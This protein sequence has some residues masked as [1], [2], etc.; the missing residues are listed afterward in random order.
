MISFFQLSVNDYQ[1]ST[2]QASAND[3]QE[4]CEL[5]RRVETL[6]ILS[7]T[8]HPPD[9]LPEV[10]T[11]AIPIAEPLSTTPREIPAVTREPRRSARVA[12]ADSIPG[13][14]LERRLA[15]AAKKSPTPSE[16]VAPAPRR[17]SRGETKEA[18]TS[19][20]SGAEPEQDVPDTVYTIP[21][22]THIMEPF[23]RAPRVRPRWAEPSDSTR[24]PTAIIM[25]ADS[26]AITGTKAAT[27]FQQ[28]LQRRYEGNRE[29]R[30]RIPSMLPDILEEH[31]LERMQGARSEGRWKDLSSA[32]KQFVAWVRIKLVGE[33][34]KMD[35]A[36]QIVNFVEAKLQMPPIPDP[37]NPGQT[38]PAFLPSSALNMV[39]NLS[40]V[41]ASLGNGPDP[42]T[43]MEY[44]EA[45]KRDGA[46]KPLHQA[47]PADL[48]H[49]EAALRKLSPEEGDGL[50][51][52]WL[53]C[54]RIGEMEHV[55]GE[56]FSKGPNGE[57]IVTFPYH[58]GDPYRLGTCI[59]VMVPE[60]WA[61]RIW[62]RVQKLEPTQKFT[63]LTTERVRAVLSSI[64]PNLSAHSIK[65]GA[66]VTLLRAGFPLPLIQAMAKH[67]DL[68]ILYH[69]LPRDEVALSL[70]MQ[71]ASAALGPLRAHT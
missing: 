49:V 28:M 6:N 1:R 24:R 20:G 47:P 38:K 35:I 18:D 56:H 54:S 39:K 66:L 31:V 71:D 70:G 22:A 53:T 45:L 21:E 7:R 69:Y 44:K 61:Q 32:W 48:S 10:P 3:R 58:K 2:S 64:S 40:Q 25:P 37:K 43:I 63:P 36:W 33:D 26:E 4:L 65:R 30:A 5:E 57:L 59:P 9:P 14:I 42:V 60:I 12:E 8:E 34:D 19:G 50:I 27:P 41:A 51:M 67:R 46:L 29:T 23:E 62:Y 17:P 68:E 11:A 55:L 13:R 52:A 16:Y 15:E